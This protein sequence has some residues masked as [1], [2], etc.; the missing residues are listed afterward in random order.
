MRTGDLI[1][2]ARC[3][4]DCSCWFCINE[5]NRIGLVLN[6]VDGCGQT[7][8]DIGEWYIFPHEV[9]KGIAEVISENR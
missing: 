3:G 6:V 1:R 7:L 8:F 9:A 4:I 5:S 2:I